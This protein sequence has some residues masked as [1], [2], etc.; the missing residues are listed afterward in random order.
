MSYQREIQPQGWLF[1]S[2]AL[3]WSLYLLW[4]RKGNQTAQKRAMFYQQ[5][6]KHLNSL[7]PAAILDLAAS[8]RWGQAASLQCS[9]RAEET[10]SHS[11][12]ISPETCRGISF[13]QTPRES[14][15]KDADS[16][17]VRYN[18]GNWAPYRGFTEFKNCENPLKTAIWTAFCNRKFNCI[19]FKRRQNNFGVWDSP[20]LTTGFQF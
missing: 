14:S 5:L 16:V 19:I 6:Q 8:W 13:C 18:L 4:G 11:A 17:V 15:D 2:W 1:H 7:R 10:T 20:L 12:W 3:P 9:R